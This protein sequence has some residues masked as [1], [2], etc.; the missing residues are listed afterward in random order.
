MPQ[1]Q[2][3]Q[4]WLCHSDRAKSSSHALAQHQHEQQVSACMQGRHREEAGSSR[5]GAPVSSRRAGPQRRCAGASPE[6]FLAA[7]EPV[8]LSILI[9]LLVPC[10]AG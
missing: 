3:Q 6:S 1:L 5:A 7:W 9:S 10:G 2:L 4:G 8:M